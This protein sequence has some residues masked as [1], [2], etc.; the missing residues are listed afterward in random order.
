MGVVRL[1]LAVILLCGG[2]GADSTRGVHT[3]H[4]D[5]TTGSEGWLFR[6]CGSDERWWFDL[7]PF[8]NGK[9]IPGWEAA[10]QAMVPRC[11]DGAATCG[12][13]GVYLEGVA[14]VS[15]MGTYGHLGKYDREVEFTSVDRS[16]AAAPA[17][18]VVSTR[19]L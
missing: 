10:M 16:L 15:A 4:G 1:V 3:V 5:L 12:H 11:P 13:N 7:T 6:P 17:E 9:T 14:R 8:D 18:C 19:P 2:C